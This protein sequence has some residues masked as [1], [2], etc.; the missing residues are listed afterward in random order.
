MTESFSRVNEMFHE[1]RNHVLMNGRSP[2]L[3][4]FGPEEFAAWEDMLNNHPYTVKDSK[5]V[6]VEPR[7]WGIVVRRMGHPGVAIKSTK[8]YLIGVDWA[9][10]YEPPNV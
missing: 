1:A 6:G 5:Y 4:L 2:Y 9:K 3:V 8:L 10:G 7:F